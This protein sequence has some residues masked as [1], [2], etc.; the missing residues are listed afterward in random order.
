MILSAEQQ[1]IYGAIVER[2][3]SNG[4]A[5]RR[6]SQLEEILGRKPTELET[7]L[8]RQLT[9]EEKLLEDL[10]A[11]DPEN[12]RMFTYSLYAESVEK[13]GIDALTGLYNRARFEEELKRAVD[14]VDALHAGSPKR[15][16]ERKPYDVSLLAMDI[17]HFKHI[18]DTYGHPEGDEVLKHIAA[19]LKNEK[20]IREDDTAARVGGEEF[21]IILP[22]T[23]MEIAAIIGERV[24]RGIETG[25][26]ERWHDATVSIGVAN[27][28]EVCDSPEDLKRFAD[29]ALYQAKKAGRNR[30][31]LYEKP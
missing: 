3:P 26:K 30:V 7:V 6:L 5:E 22:Y 28:K 20:V 15:Q 21:N 17:D 14:R 23:N 12:K 24:R 25:C 2:R 16:Y 27:Y 1:Q 9:P 10:H 19:I 18:N 31:C 11:T 4:T 8:L 29:I 13:T